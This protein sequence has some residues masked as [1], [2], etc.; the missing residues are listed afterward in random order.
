MLKKGHRDEPARDLVR[1]LRQGSAAPDGLRRRPGDDAQGQL[2]DDG[3]EL[4]RRPRRPDR[5]RAQRA[6]PTAPQAVHDHVGRQEGQRDRARHQQAHRQGA[7]SGS[8]CRSSS[9]RTRWATRSRSRSSPNATSTTSTSSSNGRACA[10][11]SCSSK[12]KTRPR[13]VNVS[14]TSARPKPA[15][16][17]VCRDVSFELKWGAS[18]MEFKP[19]ITTANQ[20]SS[21]TV[22]GW[23]RTRKV[24][25]SA[26][27]HTRRRAAHGEQ[28]PPPHHQR[29]RGARGDRRRRADLHELRSPRAR[30]LDPARP[31]QANGYRRREGRRIAGS[32]CGPG[33]RD[34]EPRR[35]AQRQV[36]RHQ[37]E[38]HHRRQR[39]HHHVHVPARE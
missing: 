24:P 16:C 22:R 3:A 28:G 31:D 13:A 37:D 7:R 30:D 38:A 6:A 36:L 27:R 26:H 18:I 39:L 5:H 23:H 20:I 25:I 14:C 33:R 9:T 21:V 29:V 4:H 17:L 32:S 35:A 10:A 11:T 12:R 34:H 19:K 8:R 15:W 2:H 1:A